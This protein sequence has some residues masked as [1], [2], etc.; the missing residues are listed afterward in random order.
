MIK[1]VLYDWDGVASDSGP[2]S[3]KS[4]QIAAN[5]IAEELGLE[6]DTASTDWGQFQGMGRVNIAAS[7]FDIKPT[8]DLAETYRER[9][10][11]T[12]VEIMGPHNLSP[13]PGIRAFLD[14]MKQRGPSQGVA[15]SSNRRIL[16]PSIKLFDMQD[17]FRETVAHREAKDDKP[18]PG[19]YLE[20]MRRFNIQPEEALVI[21]DSPGGIT[22]GRMAGALVLAIATTKPYE[23]L[24]ASTGAHLVAGDFQHAAHLLQP[25]LL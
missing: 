23:Y 19:Q 11:D 21:E 4:E 2:I 22:A 13:I 24:R 8:D 9:V 14:F 18:K 25:H 7:L 3:V 6:L 5:D 15:T 17:Y 1:A 10:I 12:T 20:L 16:D